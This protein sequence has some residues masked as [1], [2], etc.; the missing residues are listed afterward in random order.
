MA[1][2]P[3]Q[4]SC[5]ACFVPKNEPCTVPTDTSRKKVSWFHSARIQA[6]EE[7]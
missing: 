3:E 5:P 7:A 6:A 1:V 2:F 4:V